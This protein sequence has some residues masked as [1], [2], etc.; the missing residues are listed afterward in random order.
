MLVME[1]Y[2][3]MNHQKRETFVT[4]KITRGLA[5]ID[6]GLD[7]CIYLGNLE[8]KRDWGHAEDYVVMQWLMLQ[9]ET[10]DDFA[11]ATGNE[12]LEDL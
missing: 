1:F 11:I 3:T 12:Q 8:A 9:Q 6:Q 5:R 4:R 2:L 7:S 10:P